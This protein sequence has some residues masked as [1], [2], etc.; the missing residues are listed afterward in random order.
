MSIISLNMKTLSGFSFSIAPFASLQ[1][2]RVPTPE[3]AI[4]FA[5]NKDP[6]QWILASTEANQTV[7]TQEWVPQG[8]SIDAWKEVFG[9]K[10]FFTKV[11]VRE[12]LDEKGCL[13]GPVDPKAETTEEKN[14][15]GSITVT[16]TSIA[17]DEV[18]IS[19]YSKASDGIYILSY[20]VRPELKTEATFK[21][22]RGI[23]SSASLVPNPLK[24]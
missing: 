6:R 19:R 13:L 4:V 2:E 1:P 15:D 21:I 5:L 8:D 12:H 24:R 7:I 9:Q 3:M 23:I 11:S 22:W 17:G 14:L 18:G 16:S 10:I 20:R